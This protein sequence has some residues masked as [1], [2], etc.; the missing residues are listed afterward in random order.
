MIRHRLV[1]GLR[2]SKLLERLQLD[3]NLDLKKALTMARNSEAR[4]AQQTIVRGST[5][6]PATLDL[7]A[8]HKTALMAKKH[9]QRQQTQKTE[10]NMMKNG[11]TM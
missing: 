4:P 10:Q 11:P 2:E 1:V 3:W 7:A 5:T 9:G 6:T 8:L